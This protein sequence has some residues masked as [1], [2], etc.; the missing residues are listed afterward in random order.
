MS[1]SLNSYQES[2]IKKFEEGWHMHEA[3][4]KQYELNHCKFKDWEQQPGGEWLNSKTGERTTKHPGWKF[5]KINRSS[6]RKRAEESFQT[7]CL[8]RITQEKML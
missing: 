3:K 5:F 8:D 1:A 4:L 6:M 2:A 7:E